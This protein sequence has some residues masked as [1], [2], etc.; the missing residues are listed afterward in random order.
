[1]TF[2]KFIK[3]ILFNLGI[4]ATNIVVFSKAFFGLSLLTGSTLT[5]G[6][7][8]TTILASIG[9]FYYVNN[10]LLNQPSTYALIAQKMHSLDDCVAIFEQAIERGDVFDEAILKNLYQLKRYKRK[11]TTIDDILNQKFSPKEITYQKFMNV[12]NEVEDLMY[13]NMRS[14]L[15]KIA[16]FDVE[17]YE[18]LQSKGFPPNE[19]SEEKMKIYYEYIAYVK[20]ATSTNEE[21]LLKLDK[22]L[23]EISQYN[24]LKGGDIQKLPAIVEIDELIKNAKFYK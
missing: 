1:M 6:A 17:E 10:K 18:E 23:F 22:L 21:I 9:G 14:I 13:I 24:V 19:V 20:Q 5:L 12:L 15:N 16:A 3:L 2:K 11:R 7:A 4:A 8:W